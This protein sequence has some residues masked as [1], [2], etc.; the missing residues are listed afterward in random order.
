MSELNYGISQPV[1][2]YESLAHQNKNKSGNTNVF[3]L[4]SPTKRLPPFQ[5]RRDSSA[6][7]ISSIL[8]VN[9]DTAASTDVLADINVADFKLY[10][11]TTYDQIVNFG[12]MDLAST[13]DVGTYYMIV[14][15]GTKTWYS[16][17]ITFRNFEPD[18]LTASCMLTKF[19]YWS[20]CDI[21]SIFYRT[22]EAG[23]AQYKNIMYLETGIGTPSYEY[24][25]EGEE[26]A[27]KVFYAD[28][29]K[30]E[31]VY[32]IEGVFPEFMVDALALMPLHLNRIGTVEVQTY[33][34]YTGTVSKMTIDPE[35]Q[36]N[37]GAFAKVSIDFATSFAVSTNC[38]NVLEQV[39]NLCISPQYQ[40][41]DTLATNS[42]LYIA[43]QYDDADFAVPQDFAV[44]DYVISYPPTIGA[45]LDI[46]KWNGTSFEAVM[47][48][49]W[50]GE[51]IADLHSAATGGSLAATYKF[52][53]GNVLGWVSVP[54]LDIMNDQGSN[55][56]HLRGK[57]WNS[58]SVKIYETLAN[59]TEVLAKTT[60]GSQLTTGVNVQFATGSTQ[61][62]LDFEGITCQL[63]QIANQAVA[64][65]PTRGIGFMQINNFTSN[66]FKVS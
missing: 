33:E 55:I 65:I 10:A 62:R 52:N 40:A 8:L 29:Q 11:F 41:K 21:G 43:G 53:A 32:N 7:Q 5:I 16:E 45:I 4:V 6:N 57:C 2:F 18:S 13:L 9:V 64:T 61:F 17:E 54:T 39:S 66:P 60:T 47:Q 3:R 56:W 19:S 12:Q 15:D 46:E 25:E 35:W 26:D 51:D 23:D 37:L 1:R 24:E 48:T 42:A 50:G 27:E 38:C 63:G 59:G 20:T 28:F 36:G 31:K 22:T 44:D 14:T 34:G 49:S 30:L 58:C